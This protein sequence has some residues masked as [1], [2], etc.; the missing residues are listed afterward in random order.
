MREVDEVIV[1]GDVDGERSRLAVRGGV[2]GDVD[3]KDMTMNR[4]LT[5]GVVIIN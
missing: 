1:E 2:A 4:L 3:L 5:D